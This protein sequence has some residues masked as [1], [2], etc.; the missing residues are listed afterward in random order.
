MLD[1]ESA[2]LARFKE[3]DH[4]PLNPKLI[5]LWDIFSELIP[6]ESI[7]DVR[8]SRDRWFQDEQLFYIEISYFRKK[9]Y[10]AVKH[11][12]AARQWYEALRNAVGYVK[13]ISSKIQTYMA[14]DEKKA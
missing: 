13:Y 14:Q 5:S 10:I 7:N 4:V 6:L 2:V 1:P 11:K 9:I 12:G 3:K 8:L